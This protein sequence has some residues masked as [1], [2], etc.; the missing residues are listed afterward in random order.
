MKLIGWA[1]TILLIYLAAVA[2]FAPKDDLSETN[3][4]GYLLA[5]LGF[6]FVFPLTVLML[7]TGLYR[8]V[9]SKLKK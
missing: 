3:G 8:M 4:L 5:P 1:V 9:R 2:L 7:A 6:Y